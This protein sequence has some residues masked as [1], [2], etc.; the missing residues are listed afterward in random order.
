MRADPGINDCDDVFTAAGDTC[1]Y[2][3]N[4]D[5]P[6]ALCCLMATI[7][8]AVNWIF[9]F[10]VALVVI[11]VLV[12]AYYILTAAGSDEKISKGRDYIMFAAIGL[13]LALFARAVPA[14]V[15]FIVGTPT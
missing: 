15:K 12:G 8:Y 11:L 6:C 5:V 7:N 3:A 14:I 1:D 2:D 10:L 4:P 13:A 9:V